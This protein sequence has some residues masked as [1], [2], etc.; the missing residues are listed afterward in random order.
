MGA[1][2]DLAT[3][4][5]SAVCGAVRSVKQLSDT[6]VVI[7]HY[8]GD[9][10][11]LLFSN[12]IHTGRHNESGK[13]GISTLPLSLCYRLFVYMFCERVL[14]AAVAIVGDKGQAV[15]LQGIM[16]LAVENVHQKDYGGINAFG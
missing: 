16:V 11:A 14:A 10:I 13:A 5:V 9:F 15:A 8:R 7:F 6:K 1:G 12:R 2:N 4:R 3:V